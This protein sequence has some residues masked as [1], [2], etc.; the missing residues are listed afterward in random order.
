VAV[1]WQLGF[2]FVVPLLL[3][4]TVVLWVTVPGAEGTE[5]E[6]ADLSRARIRY[7]LS[8]LHQPAL[9]L[10]TLVLFLFI[11][12]WQTFTAFYPTYLVEQKGMSQSVAGWL[13]GLYFAFGV[14]VKPLAGSAYDRIGMRRSLVIALIGPVGGLFLLPFAE[15]VWTLAII[16][17]LVSTM[18]G[19]GAITQSYL[20]E[21][22]AEDMRGTGL[23]AV[24]T[25]AATLGSLGPVTF[26][27]IA[28]RGYFDEG[29]L[30]LAAIMVVVILL[31]LRIPDE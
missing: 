6:S 19:T 2:L 25:I 30:L 29:Y 9:I 1:A 7:I 4:I 28:D 14:I 18:L 21:A 12:I 20:S 13:F 31:T 5:T 16:T 24:R 8:E 15:G 11:F 26:G 17:A 23:G 27:V 22:F 3:V 10:M